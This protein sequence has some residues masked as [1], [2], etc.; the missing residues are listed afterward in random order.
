MPDDS[1]RQAV[2]TQA[3][4]MHASIAL[5][6]RNDKAASQWLDK[7]E[8]GH[9]IP[10]VQSLRATILA[11]QGQ[12]PQA[13]ALIRAVPTRSPAQEKLK[14]RAE[15]QLLRGCWCAARGLPGEHPAGPV[16]GRQRHRL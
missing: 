12:L 14:R 3:Y 2:L 8:D 1:T 6:Q 7:I 15:I 11:R 9:A 4:L 16:A 10:N 13:R 5:Q